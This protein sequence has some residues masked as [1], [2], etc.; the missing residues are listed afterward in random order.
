M[1]AKEPAVYFDKN[2]IKANAKMVRITMTDKR[3]AEIIPQ[4]ED[5]IAWMDAL[6]EVNTDGVKPLISTLEFQTALR[7][8][9][10]RE[11]GSKEEILAEAPD[12]CGDYF[13]VPKV[14]E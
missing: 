13:A 11:N 8:D 9:A 2:K 6:N 5:I 10:V 7:K 14:V 12:G 4:M 3:A 1:G